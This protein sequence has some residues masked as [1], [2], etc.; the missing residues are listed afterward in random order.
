MFDLFIRDGFSMSE[1]G[2]LENKTRTGFLKVLKAH[3][4]KQTISRIDVPIPHDK[5]VKQRIRNFLIN[6][7]RD[8]VPAKPLYG[9]FFHPINIVADDKT[10]SYTRRVFGLL[11]KELFNDVQKG[12]DRILA[13]EPDWSVSIPNFPCLI[14]SSGIL[15]EDLVLLCNFASG[16]SADLVIFARRPFCL[17][18]VGLLKDPTT[19][20]FLGRYPLADKENFRSDLQLIVSNARSKGLRVEYLWMPVSYAYSKH[21]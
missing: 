19:H 4:I 17:I 7:T 11:G 8:D 21:I 18:S 1:S 5:I 13:M 14:A 9:R 2:S 12:Q 6:M 10:I 20:A 16:F 15:L 3:S